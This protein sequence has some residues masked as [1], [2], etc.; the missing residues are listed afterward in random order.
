LRRQVFPQR[1]RVS[2][3]YI[4]AK[5]P[6]LIVLARSQ[7]SSSADYPC[8]DS[9]G[10]THAYSKMKI[11][12]SAIL[13][14]FLPVATA[15]VAISTPGRAASSL[16]SSPFDE[17]L[18]NI[19]GKDEDKDRSKNEGS[20]ID[21]EEIN[22]S[23]FQKEL[24]KRQQQQQELAN[25]VD[26]AD[27]MNIQKEADRDDNNEEEVEFD[28][29]AMRDAIYNKWGECFDV[30]FQKVSDS[31]RLYSEL[32]KASSN[33]FVFVD[34]KKVDSYGFR[35]VYLNIMPFRLGGKRFRHRTELDYLCYLPEVVS[36]WYHGRVLSV[37]SPIISALT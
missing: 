2:R 35:S 8:A 34:F 17:F 10:C 29:Y 25:D 37:F 18:G 6:F 11:K 32:A 20:D 19:F 27:P 13:L 9:V 36:R 1:G 21:D 22:L 12:G 28:G 14:F 30:D 23:S 5:E 3:Q 31:V 33:C 24:S 26:N 15:F 16:Q 4:G 7:R